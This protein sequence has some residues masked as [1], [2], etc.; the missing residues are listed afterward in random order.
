MYYKHL[1]VRVNLRKAMYYKRQDKCIY[2]Q[3]AP[4]VYEQFVYDSISDAEKAIEQ[5][6]KITSKLK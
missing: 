4:G 2:V 1:N 3:F 5:M 6:D